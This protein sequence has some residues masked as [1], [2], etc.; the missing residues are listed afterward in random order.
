MHLD[1]NISEVSQHKSV[2]QYL[3]YWLR[4]ISGSEVSTLLPR[5]PSIRSID[6]A[7]FH[8]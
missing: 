6:R 7:H 8:E 1:A 3:K 2:A 5:T 4:N